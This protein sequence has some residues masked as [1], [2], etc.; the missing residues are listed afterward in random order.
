MAATPHGL[1]RA[2]RLRG[3]LGLAS[4]LPLAA[5]VVMASAPAF[6]Q[7][8]T[9]AP[10][11]TPTAAPAESSPPGEALAPSA[12]PEPKVLVSEVVVKGI[13]GHPEQE[14]LEIAVYDAMA[15]RPGSQVTRSELQNDLSAIYASGWF[16]DVRIQPVDGPLGVRLEPLGPTSFAE[17]HASYAEQAQY[18][19]D[20]GVDLLVLET[21][22]FAMV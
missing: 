1:S 17:A 9:P 8:A 12:K 15:T 7:D 4:M 13:E 18:L 16:S 22:S 14:R 11:Q 2:L 10:A 3:S 19:V 5:G 6:A 20:T 21:F